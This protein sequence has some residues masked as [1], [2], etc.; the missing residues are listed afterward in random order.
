MLSGHKKAKMVLEIK[1]QDK[2]KSQRCDC[3][4][5]NNDSGKVRTTIIKEMESFLE[6]VHRNMGIFWFLRSG[7]QSSKVP[8]LRV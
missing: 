5:Q 6:H 2:M 1:F 7:S 3:E 8:G 4:M